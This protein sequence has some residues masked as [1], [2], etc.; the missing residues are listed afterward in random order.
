MGPLAASGTDKYRTSSSATRPHN[1]ELRIETGDRI[2]YAQTAEGFE[3]RH[4]ILDAYGV[5][6]Y[7]YWRQ[8][9]ADQGIVD[10][11]RNIR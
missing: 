3:D 7:G 8:S 10:E 1:G 11:I 2:V 5:K 4:R 6:N 9:H